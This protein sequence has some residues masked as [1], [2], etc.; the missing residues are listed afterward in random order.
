MGLFFNTRLDSV[1]SE[2]VSHATRI[3]GWLRELAEEMDKGITPRNIELVAG[4]V[5]NIVA[6]HAAINALLPNFNASQQ[7]SLTLPWMDG[8]YLSIFSWDSSLGMILSG[9]VHEIEE[10]EKRYGGDI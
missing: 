8:R 6:A 10:A 2:M 4:L 7:S 9:C 5:N 1:K 3:N